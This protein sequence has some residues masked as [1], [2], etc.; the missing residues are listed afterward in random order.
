MKSIA[1][2]IL[3]IVGQGAYS[4]NS[5]E[6]LPSFQSLLE[7]AKI[8]SSWTNNFKVPQ[9]EKFPVSGYRNPDPM[10]S[11]YFTTNKADFILFANGDVMLRFPFRPSDSKW[12][13]PD[14]F[15][16]SFDINQSSY[17]RNKIEMFESYRST[18]VER[19]VLPI[20]MQLG[21]VLPHP[22]VRPDP[23]LD[24]H[25]SHSFRFTIHVSADEKATLLIETGESQG[26]N[27]NPENYS[28]RVLDESQSK[29]VLEMIKA[30]P[31]PIWWGQKVIG[32]TPSS[33]SK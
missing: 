27:G 25:L 23:V 22:V 9:V 26:R 2:L 13:Y 16:L 10:F 4:Q 1:I 24:T 29:E 14:N 15:M 33:T 8:D 17:I 11:P 21:E 12:N 5:I 20:S 19:H 3:I 28:L 7:T 18:L 31:D 32:L 30:M 6:F